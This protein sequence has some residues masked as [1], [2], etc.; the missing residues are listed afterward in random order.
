MTDPNITS[1][2]IR[3]FAKA[4]SRPLI[5]NVSNRVMSWMSD[6]MVVT[7]VLFRIKSA[8]SETSNKLQELVTRFSEEVKERVLVVIAFQKGK[9]N[10]AL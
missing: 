10:Q 6:P 8:E 4:N 2:S 3:N 9:V 1:L 7:L 5:I